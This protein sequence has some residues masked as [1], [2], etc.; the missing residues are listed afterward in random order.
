VIAIVQSG[1][2]SQTCGQG[3]TLQDGSNVVYVIDVIHNT[4]LA[5][6]GLAGRTIRFYF[7]PSGAT[8]GRLANETVNWSAAGAPKEQN[9]TLGPAL[10]IRGTVPT[11]ARDGTN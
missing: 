11:L 5:G 4:Q 9:L 8:P 1:N 7:T 10:S 2:N 3:A 6:C